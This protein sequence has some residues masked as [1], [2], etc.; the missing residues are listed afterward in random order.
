MISFRINPHSIIEAERQLKQIIDNKKPEI[1]DKIAQAFYTNI[2]IGM[3]SDI[4]VTI[5]KQNTSGSTKYIISAHGPEA[6][7]RERETNVFKLTYDN[8]DNIMK[9]IEW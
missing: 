6:L 9:R 5:N 4:E 2:K 8:I 3:G 7:K 1:L